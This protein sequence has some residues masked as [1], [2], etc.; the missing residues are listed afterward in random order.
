MKASRCAIIYLTATFVLGIPALCSPQ[1]PG[2]SSNLITVTDQRNDGRE[3]LDMGLRYAPEITITNGNISGKYSATLYKK[4]DIHGTVMSIELAA[5]SG[6]T[7]Q[8]AAP[9]CELLGWTSYTDGT[10][11]YSVTCDIL[12]LYANQNQLRPFY[13]GF[14]NVKINKFVINVNYYRNGV[15]IDPTVVEF[16]IEFPSSLN[17]YWTD[18]SVQKS[19]LY[20]FKHH[21]AKN[22]KTQLTMTIPD[23]VGVVGD[24]ITIPYTWG[25]THVLG[26][27]PSIYQ[28]MYMEQLDSNLQLTYLLPGGGGI[29]EVVPNTKINIVDSSSGLTNTG[30]IKLKLASKF[31]YGSITSKLRVTV[32]WQ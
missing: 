32:E 14:R 10:G 31:G 16:P 24:V 20:E 30:D 6:G 9:K 11:E 28:N 8:G 26:D 13:Q 22:G 15:L 23:R 18:G 1:I 29:E 5:T 19:Q 17:F 12:I 27:V 3:I 2:N 7:S 4:T 25:V 21:T